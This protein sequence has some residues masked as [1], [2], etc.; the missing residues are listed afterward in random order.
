MTQVL[1]LGAGGFLGRPVARALQESPEFTLTAAPRRTAL[2]LLGA[3][4]ADW[5]R[6]LLDPV[7]DVIINAAGRTTG[8][9]QEVHEDNTLL[10]KTLLQHLK[11][12]R[13]SPWLVQFGSAAEY[14]QTGTEPVTESFV[15]HPASSYA[16]SK[17]DATELLL[18]QFGTGQAR[19]VVLRIFNPVGA[20]QGAQTL[21]GQAALKFR[22][23]LREGTE[24]VSFGP[25]DSARDF[26]S[27][28]DVT[29]AALFAARLQQGPPVLNVGSGQPTLSR[30]LVRA[31]ARL[32]GYRG[33]ITEQSPPSAR[34]GAVLWQ[35]A[36]LRAMT[37]LGWAPTFTLDGALE[38]LWHSLPPTFPAPKETAHGTL[39]L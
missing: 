1:L 33:E 35:Q 5:N 29:A 18:R 23:A 34:S 4:E 19:G 9:L 31:L 6:L 13:L 32:A 3:R 24:T 22:Q 21:P 20:G 36:D 16:Q 38:D 15:G 10:V 26:V 25:L 37:A 27:L 2:D 30:T 11:R 14:G 12:L 7:P 17:L 8:T 39:H 28:R